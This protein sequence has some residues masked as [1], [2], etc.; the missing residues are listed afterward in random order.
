[1]ESLL[2]QQEQSELFDPRELPAG[3]DLLLPHDVQVQ[4]FTAEHVARN[5][6]R[7]LEIASAIAEGLS[8]RTIARA[9]RVSSHTVQRIREREP[10]LIATDKQRLAR[11]MR[12]AARQSV[13]GY[14]EKLE[15]GLVTPGV[16]P[17]AAGIFTDKSLLLEGEATSRVE[18]VH[19]DVTPEQVNGWMSSLP[20]AQVIDVTPAPPAAQIGDLAPERS[21]SI[22]S[23][24]GGQVI[25]PVIQ[26]QP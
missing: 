15:V 17:I 20:A 19:I 22:S 9:Y 23:P 1:M 5:Q 11:L 13:E 25:Q 24:K 16:L 3:M 10:E 18:H 8:V 14:L 2:Q 4:R 21:E 7:Y 12:Q 26:S 6:Q